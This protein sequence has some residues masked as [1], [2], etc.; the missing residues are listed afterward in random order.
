VRRMLFEM[1]RVLKTGGRLLIADVGG[2]AFWQS[3]WG[4]IW[5]RVLMIQFGLTH[6][7]AR[8]AA[9]IQA[10]PNILTSAQ[11]RTALTSQGF[12]Q[13]EIDEAPARRRWFPRGLVMSAIA[14][15]SVS[16]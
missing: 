12:G 5:L 9:E 15:D 1:R 13:V 11:W 8:T 2:S 10:F 14:R 6:S 4:R 7:R 3:L 16:I